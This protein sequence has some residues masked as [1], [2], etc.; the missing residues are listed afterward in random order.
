MSHNTVRKLLRD[1]N[2][3]RRTRSE[4]TAIG[5]RKAHERRIQP[6]A[7]KAIELY[8][9]GRSLGTVGVLVGLCANT[10]RKLLCE[11][12]VPLRGQS[13]A[14]VIREKRRGCYYFFEV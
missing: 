13:E 3:H 5:K 1:A 12:N 14:A 6:Q 4:A 8:K 9:Q 10:V 2:V 11:A 7:V